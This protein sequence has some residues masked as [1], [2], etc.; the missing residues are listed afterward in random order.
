MPFRFSFIA[1][2]AVGF[3]AG[4]AA[5]RE[6]YEQLKNLGQQAANHPAVQRATQTAGAKANQFSK[7]AMPKLTETAKSGAS[8]VR[9][10]IGGGQQQSD[11]S[12]ASGVNG[13]GPAE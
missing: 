6:R 13:V 10:R 8:K 2:F 4:S 7:A 1:G 12:D 5:G 11:G 3:V 9:E